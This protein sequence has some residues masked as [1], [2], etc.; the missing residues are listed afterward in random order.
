M[1]EQPRTFTA[2]AERSGRWWAVTVPDVPG[3]ITQGR[4]LKE[5]A[6]M[7]RE[8]VAL[9]LDVPEDQVVVDL[10]PA[11]PDAAVTA[12]DDFRSRRSDR[13]KAEDAERDAQAAAAQALTE[14]GLSVRDAGAVLGVS[15]QRISQ[16]APTRR[17]HRTA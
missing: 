5:A 7:A 17:G 10:R 13:E 2:V 8:A 11:L 6:E 1:T 14:A 4:N 16:L 15:Y 9:V 12:L 3:A